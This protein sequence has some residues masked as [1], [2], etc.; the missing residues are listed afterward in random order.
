MTTSRH[1]RYAKEERI[2]LLIVQFSK[3]RNNQRPYFI[4]ENTK[5]SYFYNDPEISYIRTEIVPE[6]IEPVQ[7]PI[8]T[9]LL[10]ALEYKE[11]IKNMIKQIVDHRLS[12]ER[13]D[14]EGIED[15]K[16]AQS[17]LEHLKR[18]R[19]RIHYKELEMNKVLN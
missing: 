4:P 9:N 3:F 6:Q 5:S 15:I 19:E 14:K 18:E 13:I 1:L 11:R 10:M 2:V 8:N 16:R 12:K 17:E 7:N